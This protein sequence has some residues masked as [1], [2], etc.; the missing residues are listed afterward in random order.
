MKSKEEILESG[1]LEQYVLGLTNEE[2]NFRVKAYL[3]EYPELQQHMD[4]IERAMET[5]AHQHAIVPPE[6]L[7]AA[8]M[9]KIA[10]TEAIKMSQESVK[11]KW[12]SAIALIAAAYFVFWSFQLNNSI[13]IIQTNL[14]ETSKELEKLTVNCNLVNEENEQNKRLIQLYTDE[15]FMPVKL[16]GNDQQP[17]SEILVFWGDKDHQ[18]YIHVANLQAPPAGHTYQI[19]ADVAGE[20]LPLGIFTDKLKVCEIKYIEN[21]ESLNV[22]IEKSGGSDHPDVS[23]LIMS[24]KV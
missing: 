12:I 22:T 5:I 15:L 24:N 18:S 4:T 19:W 17:G 10:D 16:Q 9:K 14:S 7:K 2:E 11:W 21:A 6:D 3:N 8:T 1:I 13:Q 20:M 23:K